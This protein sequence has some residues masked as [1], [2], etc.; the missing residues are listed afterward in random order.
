[1]SKI[2]LPIADGF[3]EIETIAVID[4]LRRAGIE[5]VTAGLQS[6]MPR[7]VRGVQ[8]ITDKKFSDIRPDDFDGIV[9]P[10]GDPGWRNLAN[11]QRLLTIL[12]DFNSKGKLVAAICM[13]PAVLAR[14]GILEDRRATIYPGAERELPKPRDARVVVDGNII[15]SQGP[16][17]AIEFALA[18][19]GYLIGKTKAER[20]KRD[21]IA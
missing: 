13:A 19:V 11:S 16:G 12:K 1:M 15:T 21:L 10:G 17:T 7:S 20:I 8:V 6:S 4:V 9:L 18:I 3:E 14:A 2:L 5:V